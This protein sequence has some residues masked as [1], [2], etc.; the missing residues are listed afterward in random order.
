MLLLAWVFQDR[1]LCVALAVDQAGLELGA[2]AAFASQVLELKLARHRTAVFCIV[3]DRC[4]DI[5]LQPLR[6]GDGCSWLSELEANLV[7]KVSAKP[8]EASW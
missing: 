1:F 2:P 7:Y 6:P 5:C 8:T 4:G 3:F